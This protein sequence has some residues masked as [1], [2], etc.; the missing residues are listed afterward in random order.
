MDESNLQNT[1]EEAHEIYIEIKKQEKKLKYLKKRLNLLLSSNNKFKVVDK[2]GYVSMISYSN[3]YISSLS[4]EFNNLSF[5]QQV[6]LCVSSN[7]LVPKFTL[8]TKEYLERITE[9]ESTSID[10]FVKE[11]STKSYLR[12][13]LNKDINEQINQIEIDEEEKH[14]TFLND[15]GLSTADDSIDDY[16]DYGE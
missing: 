5:E 11:R 1:S 14:Q 4:D 7:L 8:N 15:N 3:P 2:Y 10:Q 6:D 12:F 13:V 16:E 9:E